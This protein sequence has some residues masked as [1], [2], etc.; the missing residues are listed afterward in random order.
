MEYIVFTDESYITDSRYQSLSAFSFKKSS[1]HDIFYSI[2]S[3]LSESGVSEFKW[4]KL[5][6]AK[7]YFCAEKIIKY[8]LNN[9]R[10]HEL[11]VDTIVWDT[12]DSRHAVT[13]RNDHSNYERMFFHLL[14]NSM[15]KRPKKSEWV[16]YP[17][18]RGGIDWTTVHDC[19]HHVGKR[20][21]YQE[22][23]F[24]NFF[25]DPFYSIK[26]FQE[27]E[28]HVEIPIQVADLFSGLTVFS[29]DNYDC[30]KNYLHSSQPS[31]FDE[32]QTI[33]LTNRE[34]YRCK[35]LDLFNRECKSRTLSVSLDTN[36]YLHTYK[37]ENPINFWH[38]EPQGNYDKAP[39][40][41]MRGII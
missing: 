1:Y 22:S 28:S 39:C 6:D 12:H 29:R 34:T 13:G 17:D 33:K 2:Q 3:I 11:R 23:I 37:P 10:S 24:G 40:G 18:V 5:K 38:Y 36:R 27:K 21:E 25:A 8:I 32:P 14:N 35:L 4:Q 41:T 7:Y 15:K 20:Q 9:I 30:Y 19:L 26:E 31:L 16:I